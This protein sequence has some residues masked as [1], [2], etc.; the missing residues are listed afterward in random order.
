MATTTTVGVCGGADVGIS[1]EEL[2]TDSEGVTDRPLW[3]SFHHFD[4]TP[5][6]AFVQSPTVLIID[7][8]RDVDNIHYGK[9]TGT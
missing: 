2:R 9:I 1:G 5:R 4:D 3:C 8:S 7:Y 6:L